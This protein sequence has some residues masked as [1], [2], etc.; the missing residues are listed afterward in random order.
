MSLRGGIDLG[1]AKIQAVV[2]EAGHEA[3]GQARHPTPVVGGPE[4]IAAMMAAALSEAAQAAGV[5][6][7]ELQGVG[8]CAPGDVDA[9]AGTVANANNLTGWAGTTYDL[10]ADLERRLGTR[11]RLGNDVN[12]ATLG[13][14]RLGAGLPYSSLLGV[15]WGSGVGGGVVLDGVLWEGRGAAGEI[16]HVVVRFEGGRRCSCGNLGCMEAYAGRGPMEARA[17]ELHEAGR[18]TRL[19][20]LMEHRGKDRLTSGVW[21]RALEHHDELAEELME[22]AVKAL[23]AGIASAVNLLDVPAVV[24]GGGMGL[25]FFDRV[26]TS[27]EASMQEHLFDHDHPP[28][29]V[30]AAL[31]DLGGAIGATLLLDEA[32]SAGGKPAGVR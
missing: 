30:G 13:E 17:R 6:T 27:L 21:E 9:V 20:E 2:V 14:V 23:G 7:D 22:E 32:S 3:A 26:R 15:F 19:F 5:R 28:D 12:A 1:G 4:A 11:V 29:L 18:K 31:G 8:A 16:G 25:R 24:L 10:G